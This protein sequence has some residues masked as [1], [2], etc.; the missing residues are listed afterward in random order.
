MRIST[1]LLTALVTAASLT[2]ASPAYLSG[3]RDPNHNNSPLPRG[4]ESE[5]PLDSPIIR[6]IIVGPKPSIKDLRY[7]PGSELFALSHF[8]D[9]SR[10]PL[11]SWFSFSCPFGRWKVRERERERNRERGEGGEGG[12]EG[13]CCTEIRSII[14]DVRVPFWGHL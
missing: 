5:S 12:R 14:T 1:S 4:V 11:R 2:T 9:V 6:A 10:V 13:R 7:M 3:G 8:A